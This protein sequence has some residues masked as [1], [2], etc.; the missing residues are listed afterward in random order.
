M[1]HPVRALEARS[2]TGDSFISRLLGRGTLL[3]LLAA[4]LF[5]ASAPFAK[6]LLGSSSPQGMAGLL[7]LGSGGGLLLLRNLRLRSLR[8]EKSLMR[9]D[10]PWLAGAVIAGG[11]VAPV[12]LLNGLQRTPASAASLLLNLEAVLTGLVAWLLFRE[13][14]SARIALGM[15]AVVS[16]SALLSWQGR[17]DWGGFAGPLLVAAACLAWAFD[18]NLT[19][20]ISNSDPV[21]ITMI[22]GLVAGSVNVVLALVLGWRWPDVAN[23]ILT[24][25]LGFLGYGVSLVL[26]VFALR[27]VGT[28]RTIAV[29][30]VAP[31]IGTV[32][33]VIVF[34][35]AVTPYLLVAGT[36]MA[37]GVWITTTGRAPHTENAP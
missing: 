14:F 1:R 24:A 36:L 12:L 13:R 8:N 22:K 27:A 3:A 26:F 18:N 37:S 33:G 7:Y 23:T 11:G 34:G 31:F 35:D 16:G 10:L 20:R 6:K 29:F 17:A 5:G 25:G 4:V 15:A 19:Q 9:K 21:Q 28:T 32:V 30:S 2:K